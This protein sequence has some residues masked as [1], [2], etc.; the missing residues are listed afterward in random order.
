MCEIEKQKMKLREMTVMME[1][2]SQLLRLIIQVK[3]QL[4]L[5]KGVGH[6]HLNFINFSIEN[7]DKNGG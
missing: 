1:K 7:G 4:K 2:Q 6:Y 5:I 3:S